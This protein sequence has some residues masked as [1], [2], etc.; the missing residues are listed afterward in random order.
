[1]AFTPID[2]AP[3]A[4]PVPGVAVSQA[5]PIPAPHVLLVLLYALAQTG[6]FLCIAVMLFQTREVG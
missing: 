1:M 3:D 2:T 4:A 5:A 6:V